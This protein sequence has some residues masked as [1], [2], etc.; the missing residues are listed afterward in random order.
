M[1]FILILILT[2]AFILAPI[3]ALVPRGRQSR[4]EKLRLFAR[5][6]GA[7]FSMRR[8]PA[9]K[10]E[11]ETNS[12]VPVYTLP[13]GDALKTQAEWILRRTPYAHD[14]HFFKE[15]NWMNEERPAARVQE[16]LLSRLEQLPQSVKAI[17]AGPQGVSLFWAEDE[18]QQQLSDL[19]DLLKQLKT[20]SGD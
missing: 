15:W 14:L 6:Q 11:T 16:F 9:L 19:I 8:L 17:A 1:K 20:L 2:A 5:T 12:P 13:P 7:S 18:D 10:T 3:I 4:I